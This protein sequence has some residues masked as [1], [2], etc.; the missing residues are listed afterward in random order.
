MIIEIDLNKQNNYIHPN[1]YEKI[2]QKSDFFLDLYENDIILKK[3]K[4]IEKEQLDENKIILGKKTAQNFLIKPLHKTFEKVE[5]ISADKISPL[6][7]KELHIIDEKLENLS[8]RLNLSA[9]LRPTNYFNELDNFITRKGN[10]NP[11]FQYKRPNQERLLE[12]KNELEKL[13]EKTDKL[14]S[15]MKHLFLEKTNELINKQN[16]LEAYIKQDHKN[17]A[18]YNEELFG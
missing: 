5:I 6:E 13:Q 16:L 12:T 9:K 2:K 14:E 18:L 17:I 11:V 1:F 8:K 10:Y 4:F 7:I 15:R 3:T